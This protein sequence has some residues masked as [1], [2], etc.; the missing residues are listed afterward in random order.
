MYDLVGTKIGNYEEERVGNYGEE[1]RMGNYG[2]EERM[3]IGKKDQKNMYYVDFYD[4]FDGW[5]EFGFFTDRLFDNLDDAIEL[6]DKLNN[7]LNN[8]NKSC[9]EHYGV[10]H[11]GTSGEIYCGLDEKYETSISDL[12]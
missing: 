6:C 11:G 9:G 8:G 10:I 5:G 7:E 1:E 12:K 3:E 4:I 2:E